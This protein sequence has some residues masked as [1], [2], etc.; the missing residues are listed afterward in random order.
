[1]QLPSRWPNMERHCL[2]L[3]SEWSAVEPNDGGMRLLCA[4]DMEWHR[5]HLPSRWPAL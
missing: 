4:D 5:M 3:P 2:R 1:M